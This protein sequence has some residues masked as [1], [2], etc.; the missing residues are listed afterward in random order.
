VAGLVATPLLGACFGSDEDV[1]PTTST[2][3]PA[4]GPAPPSAPL[5]G[6]AF[7]GDPAA[8]ARPALVVK[9]DNLDVPGETGRP[10]A[11]LNQADVVFEERTE[12][13]ITRFA[14]VFHSTDAD[15]IVPVRSG[16]LTDVEICS[17]LNRPLFANSGAADDVL[18]AIRSANL[19]DVS[20]TSVGNDFYYRSGDRPAP[21]N[22]ATSTP[23]LYQLTPPDA[24]PPPAL[25]TYRAA[26]S[27]PSGGR[28]IAGV[29]VEFGGG[30]GQA[31]V[32]HRCDPGLGGWARSQN[33][34]P[35]VDA[36]GAQ[37]APPN[38]IVQFV[39]Y[40]DTTAVLVAEGDALVCTEGQLIECRWS[41]LDPALPTTFVDSAG[42][43]IGLTPGPTWVLFSP[44]GGAKPL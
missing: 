39:A 13:G 9:I 42:A 21:H 2:T 20:Q 37:I 19:V 38:V 22:L 10:Q 7:T 29:R 23:V 3:A 35:H 36:A 34:T 17:M 28:P 33:G 27:S 16:R 31:P 4:T 14:S 30:T 11:G 25:F 43:P 5:T 24:Q 15:P 26:G 1:D 12:G 41:H 18:A 44:P 32:E 40:D 6:L 8:L